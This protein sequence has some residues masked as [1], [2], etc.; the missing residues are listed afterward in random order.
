M[1][2]RGRRPKCECGRELRSREEQEMGECR[3]CQEENGD[4]EFEFTPDMEMR[5][6]DRQDS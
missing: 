1:S 6:D 4:D 2:D 3:R 5:S